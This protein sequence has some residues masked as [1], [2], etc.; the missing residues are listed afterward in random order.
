MDEQFG[1][2]LRQLRHERGMSQMAL[3]VEVETNASHLSEYETGKREPKVPMVR[4]LAAALDVEP[5]DLL[6][7]GER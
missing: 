7:E 1:A 4:R 2:Q 6:R 5:G 3:A